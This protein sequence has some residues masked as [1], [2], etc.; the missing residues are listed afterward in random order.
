MVELNDGDITSGDT[1]MVVTPKLLGLG[2]GDKQIK[3][4]VNLEAG[5]TEEY[6]ILGSMS[7]PSNGASWTPFD[8]I[9]TEELPVNEWSQKTI[10][11]DDTA[12][13]GSDQYIGI[14]HGAGA[15][16]L[17]LDNFRYEFAPD[18]GLAVSA[19]KAP[20]SN[21]QMDPDSVTIELKNKG[22]QPL[23]GFDVA[24]TVN[25][26]APVTE[27]FNQTIPG[28]GSMEHTFAATSAFAGDGTYD[29]EAYH[30]LSG[31]TLDQDDTL[32]APVVNGSGS[33]VPTSNNVQFAQGDGGV[34][35]DSLFICGANADIY[36][37]GR[38]LTLTL[39]SVHHQ[40]DLGELTITLIGPDGTELTLWDGLGFTAQDMDNLVFTD[41]ASQNVSAASS[42]YT[43]TWR[44]LEAPG[45]SKFDGGLLNGM[46]RIRVF[47][48]DFTTDDSVSFHGW[49]MRTID[50]QRPQPDLGPDTAICQRENLLLDPGNGSGD[51]DYVWNDNSTDST[52]AIAASFLDTNTTYT[53]SVWVQDTRPLNQCSNT[54]TINVT[55]Q[56]CTGLE[57]LSG[58]NLSFEVHP[59]PVR[60]RLTIRSKGAQG[61]NFR[62]DLVDL[63]GRTVESTPSDGAQ[64]ST[65][66]VS[67]LSKGV[68][69]LKG[70]NSDNDQPLF[71]QKVVVQ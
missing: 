4:H 23:T 2:D 49:N 31:D 51:W 27:T 17:Y 53:Y 52:K 21:C 13:I 68:Y 19:I 6:I 12:S 35:E 47:N 43:G 36:E 65:M 60:D 56:N 71:Q 41:T 55:V 63:Q 40:D 33:L 1:A 16:E 66:D 48:D 59:N 20:I 8:T 39:D 64:R 38:I 58:G 50:P 44:P 37:C 32:S 14:A 61:Q 69:I 42:P 26:G 15:F 70:Y 67:D 34:L 22:T 9:P 57:E 45:F 62:Y 10:R 25:G 11:L 46:W 3:L 7:N 24:Y 54:D 18:T 29:I 28:F 5:G 30:M